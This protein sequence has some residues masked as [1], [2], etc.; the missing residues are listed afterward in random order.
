MKKL[1]TIL[2]FFSA[3]ISNAQRTMFGGQN[4]YVVPVVVNQAPPLVTNGL[5]LYLDAYVL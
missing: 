4:N 5:I 2:F 3:F 1:I